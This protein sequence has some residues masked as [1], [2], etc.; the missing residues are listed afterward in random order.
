MIREWAG[1]L[2]QLNF[3]CRALSPS[4][5]TGLCLPIYS[6]KT[7]EVS[8]AV[9]PNPTQDY[10]NLI[11]ENNRIPQYITIKNIAGQLVKS[12]QP[13]NDQI[14]IDVQDLQAG[15][16]SVEIHTE[17]SVGVTKFIKQ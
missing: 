16:Y 15:I 8:L 9:Y 6:L 10:I 12:Y 14:Q 11:L 5:I 3:Y 2:D 17:G 1:K 13:N 4:E 7:P